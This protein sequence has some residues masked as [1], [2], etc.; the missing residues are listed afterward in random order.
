[1]W[2]LPVRVQDSPYARFA[3]AGASD[4][5]PLGQGERREGVSND[6]SGKWRLESREAEDIAFFMSRLRLMNVGS[7][8]LGAADDE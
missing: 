3:R 4:A 8:A 5:A 1:M 6:A 2:L 7:E